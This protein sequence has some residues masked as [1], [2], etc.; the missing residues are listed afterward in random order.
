MKKFASLTISFVLCGCAATANPS[1]EQLSLHPDRYDDRQISTCG[2][3]RL[4]GG[5][6]TLEI[7]SKEIWLS[8][9][10]KLCTAQT[11]TATNAN[12]SGLFSVLGSDESL[13]LRK[14]SIE[15]ISGEC[16]LSST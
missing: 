12:I 8:S 5:K 3:V 15:P 9:T 4:G 11:T 10:S 7:N 14:A 6:C 2:S 1:P 16:S 13:V